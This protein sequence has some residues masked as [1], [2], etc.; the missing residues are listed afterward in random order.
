VSIISPFE[1][2]HPGVDSGNVLN[3][4]ALCGGYSIQR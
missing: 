2:A 3:G 1:I 4:L